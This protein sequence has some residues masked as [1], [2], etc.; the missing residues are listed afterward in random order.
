MFV[1]KKVIIRISLLTITFS[2]KIFLWM[3]CLR[4]FYWNLL[5]L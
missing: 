1:D 5:H 4:F 2:L 3:L